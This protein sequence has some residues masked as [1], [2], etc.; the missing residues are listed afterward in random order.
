MKLTNSSYNSITTAR[1][2][3]LKNIH[4]R[5]RNLYFIVALSLMGFV[6]PLAISIQGLDSPEPVGKFIDGALPSV[7]PGG[8]AQWEV[9]DAFPNL[10]FTDPSFI[11]PTHD[12]SHY[13][14]GERGGRIYRIPND[15]TTSTKTLV[16]DIS[17]N[18]AQMSDGGFYNFVLHPEFGN[19]LSPNR[20]YFYVYY[21]WKDAA[22][23]DPSGFLGTGF[24]GNFYNTYCRLARFTINDGNIAADPSSEQVM[25]HIRMYNDSHRGGGMA[26]DNDGYFYLTIGD[27][28]RYLTAQQI[29]D[30][31]EGGVMRLDVDMDLSRSHAP[32]KKMPFAGGNAD[33]ISG[34][35]YLIP[36]DNPFLDPSGTNFEEYFTLG[37]RN[38][39]RMSYDKVEDRLWSSEIGQ[40]DREEINV[41]EKGN[42]YGWS[43]RE[44]TISAPRTPPN[45]LLGTLTEPVIDFDRSDARAIIGGYVYRASKFPSLVGKFLCGDWQNDNLYALTYDDVSKTTHREYLCRFNPDELVSFGEDP[46]NGEVFMISA[47]ESFGNVRSIYKL[48]PASVA[49][50][51]PALLSQTGIFSNLST[52]EVEDYAIP[53]ELNVAFW[54]DSAAKRRWM[55]VPN[56]GDHDTSEEKINY[57][58]KGNWQFPKGA[59]LVKH[60]DLVLDES[61]PTSTRKLET[62]L[63]VH[64]DDG[65]Y[66]G[67]SYRWLD[68][69]LDAQLLTSAREDS[70]TIQTATGSKEVVWYYPDRGECIT[71]HNEVSDFVLGPS[72]RQ[73][74]K[75]ITYPSSGRNANQIKTL[76]HLEMF[77]ATVDT[78]AAVLANVESSAPTDDLS[79]PLEARARAYLDA[80]CA[81]CHRPGAGNRAFFDA[82]LSTPLESQDLIYGNVNDDIGIDGAR[83]IIPGDPERSVLYQR[84]KSVHESIAMPPLAKNRRDAKGINLIE[85]WINSLSPDHIESNEFSL[86]NT[87]FDDGLYD[88]WR[89]VMIINES[90]SYTNNSGGTEDIRI[91]EFKFFAKAEAD[92]VTPFVARRNADNDFTVLAIG[93]TRYNTDYV[94]G[95]N[96]FSFSDGSAPTISLAAGAE[97]VIGFMDGEADGTDPGNEAVIPYDAGSPADEVWTSGGLLGSESGSISIGSAPTPGSD[98]QSNL[99]RN[100][101]F[102]IDFSITS[103]SNKTHQKITFP[104]ISS[105]KTNDPSFAAGATASSGL[106][107]TYQLVAGPASVSGNT[108][109]LDG[110]PGL[111]ILEAKQSGDATYEEAPKVRQSFYVTDPAS[112]SG[113]GLLGEYHSDASLGNLVFNQVDSEI[114][115]YWANCPP[116]PRLSS[117][118][119]SIKWSGEIE[120]PVSGT[121]TFFSNTDDGVRLWMNGTLLIN[122][123]QNQ[124]VRE[125]SASIPLTAGVRVPIVME[126]YQANA[127]ASAQLSW[128]S[129]NIPQ[130]IVPTQFLYPN[131]GTFPVE[132]LDFRAVLL[133]DQVKINWE[134][135]IEENV[136]RFVIE[137]S[138]DALNFEQIQQKKAAGNR[139]E[140]TSYET[141]DEHPLNGS[142]Y[143]RLKSVDFDGKFEYSK[144]VEV[145][146]ESPSYSSIYPNPLSPGEELILEINSEDSAIAILRDLKGR[147]IRQQKISGEAGIQKIP[148]SLNDLAPGIYFLHIKDIRN[149]I[150]IHKVLIR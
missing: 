140:L 128:S 106:S 90:D 150:H 18:V 126:Y 51:A 65:E 142:N 96:E 135:V 62:R 104:E 33:E 23:P 59:V 148:F 72:A 64:G 39:Y 137:R 66:Y 141:Y 121:Y 35:G 49:P 99:Q 122:E 73:L 144:T 30:N 138:Q 6:I 84:L 41:I 37:H 68:N 86:G 118:N 25:I 88:G 27:L 4:L 10:S 79:Q 117:T 74:N 103:S 80:N 71:C 76:Q 11:V 95:H 94:P 120:V 47:G 147:S 134:T 53:Y 146:V 136:D 7:K 13:Y 38:P 124:S 3:F 1:I 28:Y 61:N 114:D 67:L 15:E 77:H 52:M 12:G 54:S 20:G 101:H 143:Y 31:L 75:K 9:V 32:I 43:F 26:F 46:L 119:F 16:L 89:A 116:D 93:D 108:I 133:E 131:G 60:F 21:T 149:R 2:P 110:N 70:F 55:I 63:M 42:N 97:M 82:R 8:V 69:Q 45:P 19:P 57:T 17:T 83:V 125:F 91:E 29:D 145:Q 132:L 107:V 123:W 14:I 100:Y 85:D 58:E 24:P 129:N 115:F 22:T 40:S 56:D 5:K 113:T 102:A 50:A 36:N 127:Y 112:G 48:A 81:Y 98:T 92:P 130:E 87:H 111:V 78:N 105:K 139:V 44:G 34:V 109:I